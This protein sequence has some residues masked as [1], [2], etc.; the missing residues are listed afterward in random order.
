[1]IIA[2]AMVFSAIPAYATELAPASETDE[3]V[4]TEEQVEAETTESENDAERPAS[5]EEYSGSVVK[6]KI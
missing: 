3:P 1:M 6:T 5:P 2:G 4:V